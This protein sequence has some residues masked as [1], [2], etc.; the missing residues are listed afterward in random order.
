MITGPHAEGEPRVLFSCIRLGRGLSTTSNE[1]PTS[2]DDY[3]YVYR[4]PTHYVIIARYISK[5]AARNALLSASCLPICTRF[6]SSRDGSG[7][8]GIRAMT[9]AMSVENASATF[10]FSVAV[11]SK[12]GQP[13]C[14]AIRFASAEDTSSV[15][16]DLLPMSTFGRSGLDES[17]ACGKM[18]S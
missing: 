15:L 4:T 11:V 5:R 3:D 2:R 8:F 12:Y 16:S 18:A 10:R 9:C 7:G 1:G 6:R 14:C 13:I 17:A